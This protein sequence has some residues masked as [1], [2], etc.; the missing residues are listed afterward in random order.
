M[1]W[2]V[3]TIAVLSLVLCIGCVGRAAA[4]DV[5]APPDAALIHFHSQDPSWGLTAELQ[6][7]RGLSLLCRGDCTVSIAPG[8]HRFS[9][10]VGRA[11]VRI[12]DVARTISGGS[13]YIAQA[14]YDREESMPDTTGLTYVLLGCGLVAVGAAIGGGFLVTSA[15]TEEVVGGGILFGLSALFV[16]LAIWV[17]VDIQRP[18]VHESFNLLINRL[19]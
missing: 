13:Q 18:R 8:H 15:K 17:L 12:F 14:T 1:H 9:L 11:E 2:R 10:D 3:L 16:A 7:T 19:E 5:P 6:G 4:Q